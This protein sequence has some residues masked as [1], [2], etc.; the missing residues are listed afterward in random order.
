MLNLNDVAY[1]ANRCGVSHYVNNRRQFFFSAKKIPKCFIIFF[2]YYYFQKR[3]E[4][5]EI[6]MTTYLLFSGRTRTAT[7]TEAIN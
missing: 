6:Y 1:L 3:K 2:Y 5:I 7:R 4:K